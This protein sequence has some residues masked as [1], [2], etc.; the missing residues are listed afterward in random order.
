M[1]KATNGVLHV[2]PITKS[3]RM[4]LNGAAAFLGA[5]HGGSPGGAGSPKGRKQKKDIKPS[6]E[7]QNNG[8]FLKAEMLCGLLEL[9]T[10]T[11]SSGVEDGYINPLIVVLNTQSDD[12]GAVPPILNQGLMGGFFMRISLTNTDRLMNIKKGVI[13]HFQR[14]AFIRV[15]DE[16][17]DTPEHRLTSLK[18]IKAFFEEASNNKFGTKVHIQEP[19]WDLTNTPLRKLDNHLEYREIVKI[20]KE[21]FLNVDGNWAL[22]NMESAMCFFTAGHIPVAA[23]ADLGFPLEHCMVMTQDIAVGENPSIAAVE[24]VGAAGGV[25]GVPGAG[26]GG[27]DGVVAGGGVADVIGAV[28]GADGVGDMDGAGDA[29]AG[30]GGGFVGGTGGDGAG[31]TGG[32]GSGNTDGI[33]AD[34]GVVGRNIGEKRKLK[35]YRGT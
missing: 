15:V 13:G 6:T 35:R 20:V 2:I 21:L 25:G 28:E 29:G 8:W 17:E 9:I 11:T 12:V 30:A 19:G 23:H 27:V 4:S 24:A 31:G 32:D 26:A 7:A 5:N 33:L 14:K 3:K 22:N 18:V 16:G 10:V 1:L 34:Q